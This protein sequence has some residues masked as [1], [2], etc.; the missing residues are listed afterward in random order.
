MTTLPE[1]RDH[2]KPTLPDQLRNAVHE[3]TA[4]GSSTRPRRR[5]FPIGSGITEAAGK[6]V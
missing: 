5:A 6:S 3:T 1:R 4:T 2:N